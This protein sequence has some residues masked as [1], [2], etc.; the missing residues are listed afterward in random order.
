MAS[1]KIFAQND[2]A[3]A[4]IRAPGSGRRAAVAMSTVQ[5]S[6]GR[7]KVCSKVYGDGG[8][9]ATASHV[10]RWIDNL[11]SIGAGS[12]SLY[13]LESLNLALAARLSAHSGF[14]ELVPWGASSFGPSDL[15]WQQQ[16]DSEIE[17]LFM[18]ALA[19]CSLAAAASAYEFV[20]NL[21]VD[22]IVRMPAIG[23]RE[24]P[25]AA[26]PSV[27]A[28]LPSRSA[29]GSRAVG[30]SDDYVCDSAEAV[31]LSMLPLASSN[32]VG[33]HNVSHAWPC[34]E[35]LSLARHAA[36]DA[37]LRR[38]MSDGQTPEVGWKAVWRPSSRCLAI[39]AH[40]PLWGAPPPLLSPDVAFLVHLRAHPTLQMREE[41]DTSAPADDPCAE[42][43]AEW[44][45]KGGRARAVLMSSP[46]C[47]M[48]LSPGFA[49]W[50]ETRP[51]AM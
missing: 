37:I 3:R 14:V 6:Q 30:A 47:R 8:A 43:P 10:E 13:T 44:P 4:W 31:M 39:D 18:S 45:P 42:V 5:A 29:D 16:Y 2:A 51:R 24:G 9:L 50:R 1:S 40:G 46:G 25:S 34:P 32:C 49:K 19:H 48:D 15:R 22:E 36:R 28:H 23:V 17:S 38:H 7:L 12:V 11:H 27:I 33:G 21:D 35:Q 41:A 20:I 26:L